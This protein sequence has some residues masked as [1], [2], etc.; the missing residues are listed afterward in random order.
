[1]TS[2]ENEASSRSPLLAV[3]QVC[4]V[5]SR[6]ISRLT[7]VPENRHSPLHF[8]HKEMEAQER[9]SLSRVHSIRLLTI[10]CTTKTR[11]L[12]V[13]KG[14]LRDGPENRHAPCRGR[15]GCAGLSCVL[16]S[17]TSRPREASLLAQR[18]SSSC[19]AAT[20]PRARLSLVLRTVQGPGSQQGVGTEDGR[21]CC[22]SFLGKQHPE[23]VSIQLIPRGAPL[24][25]A[26]APNSLQR[27]T[28]R[29]ID[30][31]AF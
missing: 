15:A 20:F 9:Q 7:A 23:D 3:R 25:E 2:N 29:V 21:H 8:T 28:P 19:T 10:P 17:Q 14:R 4:Q 24:P 5:V 18:G 13:R 27:S 30:R 31:A 16:F 1:M 11:S 6:V 26:T 12:Q 22:C